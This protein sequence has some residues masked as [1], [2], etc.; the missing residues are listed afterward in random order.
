MGIVKP[1]DSTTKMFGRLYLI[2]HAGGLTGDF[3]NPDLY[4]CLKFRLMVLFFKIQMLGTRIEQVSCLGHGG[5][6]IM[7]QVKAV[8]TLWFK[9]ILLRKFSFN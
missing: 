5:D 4:N 8:L 7:T 9:L 6:L 2:G 1:S 3:N